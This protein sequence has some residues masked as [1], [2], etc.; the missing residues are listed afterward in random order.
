MLYMDYAA[1]APMLPEVIEAMTE[2]MRTH[3][4]NPSS[5]HKLGVQ[6]ELLVRR[7]RET[8]AQ[9][10]GAEPEEIVFTSGGTESNNWA[11][12]GA[13]YQ[14]R[15]RGRHLIT[16]RIEHA[17]VYE[18]FRQLEEEGFEVTYLPVD[19]TGRISVEQLKEALTDDT[20]LVSV[21]AVNNE[22]GA[23]QPIEELGRVLK[24]YPKV[25]L[26]VDA[27][28]A[29]GKM[30][31]HPA[32][33]GADLVSF[34]AH[35]IGGPK[36]C[37]FLYVRRGV[38]LR[39]LLV[40]GGQEMALRAGTENVPALVGTAKAVRLAVERQP[41]FAAHTRK[42]KQ[43]IE[44]HVRAFDALSLTGGSSRGA[45]DESSGAEAGVWAPHLVHFT[46]PGMKSEV[47]IHALEEQ[48]IC[49]SARSACSSGQ[50][51]PSRV[52]EAMGLPSAAAK[53]GIRL[54]LAL[55][56]TMEDAESFGRALR[57]VMA[58]LQPHT[59]SVSQKGRRA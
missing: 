13:A 41:Q 47:L 6:A 33:M 37:G 9:Q 5:L 15:H 53:A 8:I 28:Q 27:V 44:A 11:I 49:A 10:L 26:H 23:I 48:G 58:Q 43:A 50:E 38:Q 4:G 18:T 21:M 51:K 39:P 55:D 19:E 34:A 32:A 17:S 25:L 3:Y 57:H 46:Y 16:T 1:T 40:G 56:H 14:Y 20:S 31:V 7:S 24:S 36:G 42:L 12:R 29:L 30:P 35:K 2:V 52:L 22:V 45:R 59:A 54:S